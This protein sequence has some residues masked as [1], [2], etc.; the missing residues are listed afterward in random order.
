MS[1]YLTVKDL[2]LEGKRV[3][4][5]VDFNVPLDSEGRIIDDSKMR[6]SLPTLQY[7]LENGAEK[8]IVASHLGRPGGK[9]VEELRMNPVA[10]RLSQLLGR[11][12]VKS[13]LVAGVEVE[14]KIASLPA[15][16]I[17]FL[18][19]VRFEKGEEKNDP[20]LAVAFARLADLFVNDA[21]ATAHRAH[22]SNVGLADYLPAA[23]GLLMEKEIT[24]LSMVK[25]D[26]PRPLVA[27]LGGKKIA[28]KIGVINSFL[29]EVDS[30]LLGGGMANTFLSAEGFFMGNSFYDQDKTDLAAEIMNK[31]QRSR[32]KLFLPQD[33]VVAKE[34]RANSPSKAV[35]V[36]QI[37]KGWGA[38]D[39]GP[40]TVDTFKGIIKDARAIL[41]N[42][43]LGAY[44]YAPF[45]KGTEMIATAVAETTAQSIVG[46]GDIVAAL[47]KMGLSE[48]ITHLST[49]G[50]AVLSFWEGKQLPGII[51]LKKFTGAE[52]LTKEE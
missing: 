38:V 33:V 47:G 37:P 20:A 43:P 3:F 10:E 51:A 29:Q 17:V 1:S 32:A 11:T 45:H 4:V 8:I 49:G 5:R 13:D 25:E 24:Y 6:F 2:S 46:G 36:D 9:V 50:G 16:S 7:L 40:Q 30:L 18:E 12:V 19:N 42:G 35:R 34:L 28:D 48:K 23:A 41:W 52:G 27:I 31:A 44:E 26:P 22:A 14:E 15:G 39:L 21:F